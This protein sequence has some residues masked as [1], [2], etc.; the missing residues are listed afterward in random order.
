M[1]SDVFKMTLH[2]GDAVLAQWYKTQICHIHKP[3]GIPD[4]KLDG[5]QKKVSHLWLVLLWQKVSYM[6]IKSIFF[7]IIIQVEPI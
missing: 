4:T 3:Y 1:H 7:I 5:L 6:T 2:R